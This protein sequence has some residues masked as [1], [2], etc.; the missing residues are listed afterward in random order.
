M[1]LCKKFVREGNECMP[2]IFLYAWLFI[3]C[4]DLTLEGKLD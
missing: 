4:F 1:V 3:I 2:F